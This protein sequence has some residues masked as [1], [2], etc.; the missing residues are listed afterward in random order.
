ML[1]LL[2]S[3]IV[4]I[5]A[6]YIASRLTSG[7]G[8]GCLVDLILGIVGG[9]VGGWL[10]QLLNITWAGLIGQIGTSA[11]G[12]VVLLWLWNKLK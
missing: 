3:V 12:A 4:G 7:Q 9:L 5:I 8:K 6:G 1:S 11:V 2:Y 10:F